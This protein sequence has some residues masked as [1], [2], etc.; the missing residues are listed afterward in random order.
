MGDNLY[1]I[2]SNNKRMSK[3]ETSKNLKIMAK[4]ASLTRI[5][6]IYTQKKSILASSVMNLIDNPHQPDSICIH[7]E[8]PIAPNRTISTPVTILARD[9]REPMNT[10]VSP[11]NR[12]SN[13]SIKIDFG[14][15]KN[16]G[17]GTN[18][19]HGQLEPHKVNGMRS[20]AV[21]QFDTMLS[22]DFSATTSS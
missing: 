11:S 21:P 9:I 2:S 19:T 17:Q 12:E 15:E 8:G 1:K 10:R 3:L 22:E 14:T 18:I 6:N 13:R 20:I 16:E 7:S 5:E 4:V